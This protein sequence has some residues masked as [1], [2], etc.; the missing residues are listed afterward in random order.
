VNNLE[1]DAMYKRWPRTL[2]QLL[3]PSWSL[4][5]ISRNLYTVIANVDPLT[6]AG[7]MLLAQMNMLYQQ[8][9]PIRFGIVLVCSERGLAGGSEDYVPNQA[10]S[11]DVC[12]LFAHAKEVRTLSF[13]SCPLI[14]I[15]I[16]LK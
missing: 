15:F 16:F 1:K 10:S 11:A 5:S 12:R 3:Y 13:T 7:A 4:H 8:Q 14:R 9:Y 6:I 2:R